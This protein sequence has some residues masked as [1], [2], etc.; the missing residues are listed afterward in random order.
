MKKNL[1]KRPLIVKANQ[2]KSHKDGPAGAGHVPF[3]LSELEKQY[4]EARSELNKLRSIFSIKEDPRIL[5]DT[6]V[7][8]RLELI[9][10]YRKLV[11]DLLTSKVSV[12]Q[13][14]ARELDVMLE[15]ILTDVA[16]EVTA[17]KKL[18]PQDKRLVAFVL[19]V[20]E[21]QTKRRIEELLTKTGL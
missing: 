11:K 19:S 6:K 16:T 10:N 15:Q 14:M 9:L 13:M 1:P 7:M 2:L 5:A 17:Q 18:T 20:V 8:K 3:R 21:E 12:I 4:S